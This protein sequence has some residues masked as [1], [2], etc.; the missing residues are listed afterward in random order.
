MV[1]VWSIENLFVKF[2]FKDHC[3]YPFINV[4]LNLK[5]EFWTMSNFFLEKRKLIGTIIRFVTCVH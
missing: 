4:L 2:N 1:L 3:L 5:R